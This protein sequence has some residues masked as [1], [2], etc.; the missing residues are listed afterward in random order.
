ME[1][2]SS[3]TVEIVCL[4]GKFVAGLPDV[5]QDLLKT[6]VVLGIGHMFGPYEPDYVFIDNMLFKRRVPEKK[7][8]QNSP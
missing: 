4:P 8:L 3:N 5:Q 6:P 1:L 7:V 2:N